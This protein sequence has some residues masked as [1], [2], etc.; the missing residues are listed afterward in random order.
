MTT[1]QPHHILRVIPRL[2]IAQPTHV[3]SVY[4]VHRYRVQREVAVVS[5]LARRKAS[6]NGEVA[7]PAE[8]IFQRAE[9]ERVVLLLLP[10]EV[11][12][13]RTGGL[14]RLVRPG[15]TRR[16]V[17]ED[18]RVDGPGVDH[19]GDAV[20]INQEACTRLRRHWLISYNGI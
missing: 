2:Q 1:R 10:L 15:G 6:S 12:E 20:V 7:Q 13:Q 17:L 3:L 18:V 16:A 11:S 19:D 5:R 14:V 8:R 4:P 9:P